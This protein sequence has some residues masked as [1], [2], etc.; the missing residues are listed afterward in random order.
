MRH[1]KAGRRLGRTT[2]HRKA[3]IKNLAIALLR[4]KAIETT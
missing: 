3:T 1:L 4:N 2:S